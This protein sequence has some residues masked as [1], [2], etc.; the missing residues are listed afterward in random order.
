MPDRQSSVSLSTGNRAVTQKTAHGLT[1]GF[2]GLVRFHLQWHEVEGHTRKTVNGY[3]EKLRS[4]SSYLAASAPETLTDPL[5]LN[6]LHIQGWMAGQ[7]GRGVG[8]HTIKSRFLAIRAFFKWAVAWKQFTGF[9]ESPA[10]ALH[11]PKVPRVPKR[12]PDADA[13]AA[14]LSV[15]A[16]NTFL[17]ARR[18]AMLFLYACTGMRLQELTGLSLTDV[19]WTTRVV[20][21]NNAKGQLYKRPTFNRETHKAL[22]VYLS[23]RQDSDPAL[24]VTQFGR[25]MSEA[26]VG[27]DMGR[28]RDRSGVQI[29]DANHMLRRA[30]AVNSKLAGV[31]P[32]WAM[33]QG[34]WKTRAMYDWYAE[35]AMMN[36]RSSQARYRD[37]DPFKAT[38]GRLD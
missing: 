18:R 14:L 38:E 4:L 24:W 32:E 19:D 35:E 5:S 21:V 28:V 7:R 30:F 17:G 20:R 23:F 26:A 13:F 9:T 2:A 27:T 11:V 16:P 34:G 37:W 10:A 1:D 31:P 3:A 25:R 12:A 22:L 29:R 8:P 15:C 6:A 36:E 33:L